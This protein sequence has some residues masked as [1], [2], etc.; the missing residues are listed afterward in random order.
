MRFPLARVVKDVYGNIL[1]AGDLVAM[2]KDLKL[3]NSSQVL[4]SG[5]KSKP[6]RL[7]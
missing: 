6:I 4:K 1:A 5:T 2:I 3:K 7:A